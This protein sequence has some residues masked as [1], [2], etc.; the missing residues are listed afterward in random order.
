MALKNIK[1]TVAYEGTHYLGWQKTPMGESIEE[2]L[3]K[4][5]SKILQH[6]VKLQAASR[7]D[8]GVHARGQIVN[9]F[10]EKEIDLKNINT[11]TP[12]DIS[13]LDLTVMPDDFHPTLDCTGK[14]YEYTVCLGQSQLPFHRL[15]SWHFPYPVDL[16]MTRKGASLLVGRHDF[17]AFTNEKHQNNIREIFSIEIIPLDHRIKIQVAGNNFLYKMVR[18]IVGTLIYVGCG[19]LKASDLPA[20]LEGKDRT[21]AGV[22]APAHGLCLKKVFYDR[23]E[24]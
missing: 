3:E 5:V 17:S 4:A 8:A 22:T 2:E 10:T 24:R 11:V 21:R 14:E 20:I 7:T 16:E 1:L 15:F 9:F 12:K 19:K 13:I 18:N 23:T 6:P